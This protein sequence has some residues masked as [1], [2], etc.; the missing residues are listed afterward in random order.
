MLVPIHRLVM[1]LG[2]S[3]LRYLNIKE[4]LVWCLPLFL[5]EANDNSLLGWC[6]GCWLFLSFLK[7]RRFILMRNKL[8]MNGR[9]DLEDGQT[10]QQGQ[11][12]PSTTL[13]LPY[14]LDR[15]IY[16]QPTTVITFQKYYGKIH[17]KWI[18]I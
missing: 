12:I 7:Q 9:Q 11:E 16:R 14:I 5:E 6:Y 3:P 2:C 4:E 8:H 18:K 13:I 17:S 15:S 1:E 10:H